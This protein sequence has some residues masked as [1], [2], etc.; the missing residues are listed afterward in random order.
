MIECKRNEW[1]TTADCPVSDLISYIQTTNQMRDAQVDAIKT[2][3]YLKIACENKLL[4]ELFSS[5]TF[6]SLDLGSMELTQ[7]TRDFY[8]DG[9]IKQAKKWMNAT[10]NATIN[11]TLIGALE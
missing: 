11:A 4:Y 2:Y 7:T 1:L 6:N 8:Y 9:D 5:G 10:I 3:L